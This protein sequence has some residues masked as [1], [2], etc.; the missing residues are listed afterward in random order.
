MFRL[1]PAAQLQAQELKLAYSVPI[2]KSRL[3][4]KPLPPG[5]FSLGHLISNTKTI[6]YSNPRFLLQK[7]FL[8]LCHRES[9]PLRLICSY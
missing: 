7:D 2:E 4:P 9:R 1:N 6:M 8:L 5:I 3:S